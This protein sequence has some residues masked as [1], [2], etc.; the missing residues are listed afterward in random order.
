MACPR[1][2]SKNDRLRKHI[3][4]RLAKPWTLKARTSQHVRAHLDKH[5]YATPHFSWDELAS[6]NG[7]RVP[8][9]LRSNAIRHAWNLERFRHALGDVSISIDGPYRSPSYNR[10]VGGA[11]NSRHTF[12]DASDFFAAQV[13]R[14]VRQSAKLK[15]KADV[16]RIANRIWSKGGVGNETSGTLHVDSR[17]YRARFVTWTA[18][19]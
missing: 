2:N 16:L 8:A 17:G 9:R 13:D 10:Q 12:A 18:A 5:G 4:S 14:W 19:R 11:Q 1:S 15:S 3:N 7:E 6:N